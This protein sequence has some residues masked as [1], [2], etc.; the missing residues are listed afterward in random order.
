MRTLSATFV[1]VFIITVVAGTFLINPG[2]A[3]WILD[4]PFPPEIYV[5]SP[6]VDKTYA[7]SSIVFTFDG[8]DSPARTEPELVHYQHGFFNFSTVQYWLDGVIIGWLADLSQPFSATLTG[9][10]DG[11]HN[12]EVTASATW[13]G[14]YDYASGVR[15]FAQ[16]PYVSSGKIYF[17]VD[18]TPP[19]MSILSLQNKTYDTVDIPLD[20]TLSE[21]VSW[22]GYSL[23][24]KANIT[25]TERV[26]NV[27]DSYG[28]FD[29][30]RFTVNMVLT[31]LSEG[32]HSL[33]IY[34]K[35][36]VGNMGKSEIIQFTIVKETE[37]KPQPFPH[38]IIA[39]A[40]VS[41]AAVSAGLLLF[42]FW[43]RNH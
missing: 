5:L 35:D 43:K 4:P 37:L 16:Y 28:Q 30:V 25:I 24:G 2:L 18:T 13:D 27:T 29:I 19:S 26:S 22:V 34:A 6:E 17:S 3:P 21:P 41:V 9:L 33:I 40:F 38:A 12:V 42:Y 14:G 7:V 23:N 32:S 15:L 39:T 8:Q 10:S 20:F 36:A 31:E 1:M 11:R